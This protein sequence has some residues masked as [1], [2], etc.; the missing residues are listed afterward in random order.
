MFTQRL[1]QTAYAMLAGATLSIAGAGFTTSAQAAP[2]NI[3]PIPLTQTTQAGDVVQV[4]FKRGFR[5][6]RGSFK[7]RSFHR[8]HRSHFRGHS[9]S[10]KRG[11]HRSSRFSRHGRFHHGHRSSFRGHGYYGRGIYRR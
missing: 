1:K 8:G 6:H 4:G 10:F 7:R 3:N 2:L 11:H 5:S 9:R